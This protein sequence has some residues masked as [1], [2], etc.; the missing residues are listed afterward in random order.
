ML[1]AN[2]DK[3]KYYEDERSD[4]WKIPTFTSEPLEEDLE[5]VGPVALRFW[6]RTTFKDRSDAI[7]AG[8]NTMIDLLGK[9]LGI[10]TSSGILNRTLFDE[11]VQFV[12]ELCDVFPD[13]R[14][15]GINSGW[16]RASHRQR[17]RD[18]SMFTAEHA[19]D[20]D[21]T[22]F[23]PLYIQQD[24][25]PELIEEGELYEYVIELWPSCNVF[26][27]GH[28]IR[29]TLTGSDW[30]HLLPVL[31]PSSNEIVIDENHAANTADEGKTWKW[32]TDEGY[33]YASFDR[34]LT[35]H[36]DS[37]SSPG[38]E[39]PE[40]D[41]DD[42]EENATDSGSNGS[43]DGGCGSSAEASVY[44]GGTRPILPGMMNLLVTMLFPLGLGML[45]RRRRRSRL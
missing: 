31:V 35:S 22:P 3:V 2:I 25:D 38:T 12:A 5:I 4:D 13:G 36:K 15:R 14:A 1:G 16:L 27:K 6:A 45:H 19:V 40:D 28:R 8:Q 44:A 30:P 29:V 33:N 20:P 11:D 9:M 17:D 39:D 26:K 41:A 42:V 21:Y 32:I 37:I 43:S 18:E 10:D 24:F 23:D 34:Y 7:I